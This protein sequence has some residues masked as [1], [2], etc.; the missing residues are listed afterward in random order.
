MDDLFAAAAFNSCS[1]V[2]MSAVSQPAINS[3]CTINTTTNT[4]TVTDW[5]HYLG[6][7]SN[8]HTPFQITFYQVPLADVP[9][10]LS[11]RAFSC[12]E[13]PDNFTAACGCVDCDAVCPPRP[14]PKPRP[15]PCL[16]GGQFDCAYFSVL[17]VFIA[18]TVMLFVAV[19]YSAW[20]AR[21]R[22]TIFDGMEVIGARTQFEGWLASPT[23]TAV[24]SVPGPLDRLGYRF[25][26]GLCRVFARWGRLC[27]TSTKVSILIAVISLA[28]AVFC[29]FGML[30]LRV[31]TDP[32]EL[33]SSPMSR[34]H[35]EYEYFNEQFG[36][37]WRIEQVIIQNRNKTNVTH[38]DPDFYNGL[39]GEYNFSS[40]YDMAFLTKFFL[41]QSEIEAIV[42]DK[43]DIVGEDGAK[44][45]TIHNVTLRNICFQP[46]S[47]FNTNCSV[48]SVADY[49][50]RDV[51]NLNLN[52]SSEGLVVADYLDH[53]L[54]CA[55]QPVQTQ[56]EQGVTQLPCLGAAG[57]PALPYVVFGGTPYNKTLNIPLYYLADTLI[58]TINV[59][60]P[61]GNSA[62]IQMA[63][64]WEARFLRLIQEWQKRENATMQ[65]SY[66]AQR[67]I[68]DELQRESTSDLWTIAVSYLVMFA[69]ITVSLGRYSFTKQ[70]RNDA[71]WL[72]NVLINAKITVGL[73]GVVIVLLSVAASVGFYSVI[74]V[75]ATL[76]IVE[77][78]PFLVLAVGVDNIFILVQ[79]YQR[80]PVRRHVGETVPNAISRVVS[81]VGPSMLLSSATESLCFFLAAALSAMP[82]VR[83]FALFAALAV[84]FD[85]LLQMT[86]FL[87]VLSW[88]LKRQHS[89]RVDVICCIPIATS[90]FHHTITSL[91]V[92]GSS[93]NI[94]YNADDDADENVRPAVSP[95]PSSP[96]AGSSTN[97]IDSRILTGATAATPRRK[98]STE[99]HHTISEHGGLLYRFVNWFYAPLLLGSIIKR[100]LVIVV[101]MAVTLFAVA[102]LTKLEIGLDQKLAMPTDS[103][104]RDYFIAEQEKLDAGAPVFFVIRDSADLNYTS[105][106]Q[107]NKICGGPG[108]LN[109]SVLN[110]I[111]QAALDPPSSYIGYSAGSW[112][113][114]FAVWLDP[115]GECCKLFNSNGSFCPSS[116]IESEWR[117]ANCH[118]CISEADKQQLDNGWPVGPLFN[119][120]VGDFVSDNPNIYCA[121]AGHAAYGQFVHLKNTSANYSQVGASAFMTYQTVLRTDADYIEALRAAYDLT[122]RIK[123][124]TGLNVFPYSIF[125][126]FYEQYLHIVSQTVLNILVPL[127]VVFVITFVLLGLDWRSA[128]IVCGTVMMIEADLMAVMYWWNIQLNG[129]SLV[130]LVMGLGIAVE[131]CSHIVRAF[132]LSVVGSCTRLERARHALGDIGSSVLSGITLTKFGG[133]IVLAFSKSQLFQIFYFRMYLAIVL[134]G[135]AHGL[136]FLPVLLSFIGKC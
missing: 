85:F 72:S 82:A 63:E 39:T 91:P 117:L 53:L 98:S 8:G 36:K 6:D 77:V 105:H 66:T 76:I 129:L 35:E 87:C 112:L 121:K 12:S 127:A 51:N 88:D 54:N 122:D 130:N 11:A 102:S 114:D 37:F 56:D 17:I 113:D 2:K 9:G 68:E 86:C 120:F 40:I 97:L 67:S 133:I 136:V 55:A 118:S 41:L 125:Y 92:V 81:K 134:I 108:C 94:A 99:Y 25:E 24:M 100:L 74:G 45:E 110:Q 75:P 128:L 14:P 95:P 27:S 59:N 126:V 123:E 57:A 103:Y 106:E 15:Q 5:L 119:Q 79:A 28:V 48:M 13:R 70:E 19:C 101:F 30:K 90:N 20:R 69:Y 124:S 71:S 115:A 21:A 33:W 65:I 84:L 47:P 42:V 3:A 135:A 60:S 73:V 32:V 43:V 64:A 58:I 107:Q 1:G 132:A 29:S 83:D 34:S 80:A 61:A 131:F 18:L 10:A 22:A 89:Q 62:Q 44:K 46:L 96:S 116:S 50:Q 52:R 16:V 93:D 26:R 78:V 49:F 109:N 4:C 111:Y 7:Y 23:S 31:I 38:P 104:V